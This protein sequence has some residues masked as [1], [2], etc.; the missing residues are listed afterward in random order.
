MKKKVKH[1][2]YAEEKVTHTHSE[3]TF[4]KCE[5]KRSTRYHTNKNCGHSFLVGLP[6]KNVF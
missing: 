3:K 1:L 5:G 2:K 4:F 6:R